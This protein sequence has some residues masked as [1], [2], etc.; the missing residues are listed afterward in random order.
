M[1]GGEGRFH[2]K[3]RS[4]NGRKWRITKHARIYTG[5]IGSVSSWA[6]AVAATRALFSL[7][8]GFKLRPLPCYIARRTVQPQT[9]R[10]CFAPRPR[11]YILRSLLTASIYH[12][13]S[14]FVHP[15]SSPDQVSNVNWIDHSAKLLE[16]RAT[17]PH[18]PPRLF[19]SL[20]LNTCVYTGG[21]ICRL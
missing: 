14:F 8:C 16:T 6:F 20:S 1:R 5:A 4:L 21:T 11:I 12:S 17:A 15:R 19:F 18:L 7:V 10:W 3:T 13:Y 9:A 2:E